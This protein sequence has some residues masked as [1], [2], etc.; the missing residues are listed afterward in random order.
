MDLG[1]VI[2]WRRFQGEEK[3]ADE[4]HG[5]LMGLAQTVRENIPDGIQAI[6]K[7]ASEVKGGAGAKPPPASQQQGFRC[8]DCGTEFG[9]PAGWAGE[10][11]KCPN[12]ACG[13]EYSK[14]ELEGVG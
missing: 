1:Q 3:R 11:I 14:A 4:R 10:P 12:P 6:T 5:T 8:G 13:R 7:A 2:D 9:P